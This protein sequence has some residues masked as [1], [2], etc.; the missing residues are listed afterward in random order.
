MELT[1]ET[2]ETG[3]FF[4]WKD[5]DINSVFLVDLELFKMI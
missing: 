4:V 2:F 1:S 5:I 3:A